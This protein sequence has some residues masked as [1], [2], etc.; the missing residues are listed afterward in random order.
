MPVVLGAN[1][2]TIGANAIETSKFATSTLPTTFPVVTPI[3]TGVTGYSY[4]AFTYGYPRLLADSTNLM[5]WYKFDND[6]NDSSGNNNDL[7][8]LQGTPTLST[9]NFIVEKSL[10]LT[11]A[12]LRTNGFTFHNKAF[13]IAVW[14]YQT[15]SGYIVTQHK[16]AGTSLSLHLLWTGTLYRFGFF[17]NDLD[18]PSYSGDLNIWVH[19]VW[20]IDSNR[21]REIWRNGV[22]VANDIASSLVNTD[23]NYVIIG[24]WAHSSGLFGGYM[25]DLRCYNKALTQT[26]ILELYNNGTRTSYTVNFPDPAGTLCDILVVGGGGGG[27]YSYVAGGGG[28][29]GYISLLN[30][31]LNGSY[32]IN[33]GKGGFGGS[34]FNSPT[35]SRGFNGNNSSIQ[36]I[37]GV[38]YIALGGGGGGSYAVPSTAYSSGLNGGSGG[39][40]SGNNTNGLT[41][42]NST[43][44]YGIGFN[45]TIYI[46]TSPATGG[47]GG[48]AGGDGTG[49]GGG[50]GLPNNITGSN[51]YYAGGGGGGI[52]STTIPLKTGGSGIG[53]NGG[54][55]K[56]TKTLATSGMNNTGSG[57]GGSGGGLFSGGNG[58]SGIVIIRYKVPTN[59]TFGVQWIYNTSNA[60]VYYPIGGNV[61][62]GTLTPTNTLEV[63]G[64]TQSTT[65][66]AGKKTF[67]IEHP[68]RIKKWL[69]HGCIEGPR[70]DN[71]YRGKKRIIEGKAEVDI[72]K[73]CNTTGGMTSGTFTALNINYQLYLQN[74]E[75]Y[76]IVKGTINN[77]IITIECENI[78]D[79]I[80]IDWLVV[81]ERHDEHVINTPLTDSDGNLICEHDMP[82]YVNVSDVEAENIPITNVDISDENITEV[83]Y[84]NNEPVT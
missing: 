73:E 39:G 51:I 84:D 32:I 36:Q 62:I 44:G 30:Q 11:N 8:T 70:F 81:G 48:G 35:L 15:K 42:Q 53:G 26:E 67:K 66:S 24:D 68:L 13:S 7:T 17:A 60:N 76:D 23:N 10:F 34:V 59:L 64:N 29:G 77:S 57:G 41:L 28:A 80:E 14:V 6:F 3:D 69:Y 31:T 75:T 45:G 74:N 54:D 47:G 12:S 78:T 2:I 46:S 58:G 9:T 72:D 50:A 37:S 25:D 65:Y 20:Q 55:N 82:G 18:S 83:N 56:S 43:Y 52:D 49:G 5:A 71:I 22:R 1:S 16:S 27:G 19:L 33:V 63:L 21:N 79:E 40:S 61:G 38:N 4:L